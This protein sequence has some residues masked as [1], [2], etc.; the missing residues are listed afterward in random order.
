MTSKLEWPDNFQ[1]SNTC[2]AELDVSLKNNGK[3]S[4]DID[5]H[6]IRV[7]QVDS[8]QLPVPTKEPAMFLPLL[9]DDDI[10]WDL[11]FDKKCQNAK[12]YVDMLTQFARIYMDIIQLEAKAFRQKC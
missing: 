11:V 1:N 3:T 9:R 6:E 12:G 7:W 2:W 5:S 8:S 4:F 10:V